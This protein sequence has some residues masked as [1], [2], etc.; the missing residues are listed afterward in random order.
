MFTKQA[1]LLSVPLTTDVCEQILSNWIEAV[2]TFYWSY[3][4]LVQRIQTQ[5]ADHLSPDNALTEVA[6]AMQ[7][8]LT[9]LLTDVSQSD[10]QSGTFSG[11]DYQTLA[12]HTD[13]LNRLTQQAQNRLSS[14][15]HTRPYNP[16]GLDST[17]RLHA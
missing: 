4:Q 10:V 11:D 16:S 14:A 13:E 2:S 7:D 3:Q 8:Q 1:S 17:P 6:L 9:I 12:Q 15:G 5:P